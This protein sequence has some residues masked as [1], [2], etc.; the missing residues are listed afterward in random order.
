MHSHHRVPAGGTRK[1]R[2]GGRNEQHSCQPLFRGDT[3]P[4]QDFWP[5]PNCICRRTMLHPACRAT[6]PRPNRPHLHTFW[7]FSRSQTERLQFATMGDGLVGALTS[8]ALSMASK[9]TQVPRNLFNPLAG[10]LPQP[11]LLSPPCK[12]ILFS[13]PAKAQHD[14]LVRKIPRHDTSIH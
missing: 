6:M 10:R 5:M 14:P 3:S 11:R 8:Q 4:P 12:C 9:E 7:I 2:S 13:K 1:P